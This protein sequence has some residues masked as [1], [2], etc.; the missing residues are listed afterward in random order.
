M[1]INLGSFLKHIVFY[2]NSYTCPLAG[3]KLP[4]ALSGFSIVSGAVKRKSLP[5]LI[6]GQRGCLS[7]GRDC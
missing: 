7:P 6:C 2:P 4:T 1:R 5:L 3:I